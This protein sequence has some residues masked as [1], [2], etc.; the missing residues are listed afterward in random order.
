MNTQHQKTVISVDTIRNMDTAYG[1]SKN[2]LLSIIECC[3]VA[4]FSG[5]PAQEIAQNALQEVQ[6]LESKWRQ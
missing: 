5:H 3:K 4:E 2:A 1:I 6:V